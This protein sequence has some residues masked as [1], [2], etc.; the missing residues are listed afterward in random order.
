MF[1]VFLIPYPV[2]VVLPIAIP[3]ATPVDELILPIAGLLLLHVPL[4]AS[5]N[6]DAAPVHSSGDPDIAEGEG[7]TVTVSG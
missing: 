4:P 7:F 6:V 3:V 1:L 5:V 2:N